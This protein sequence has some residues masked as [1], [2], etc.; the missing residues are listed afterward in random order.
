MSDQHEHNTLA[1]SAMLEGGYEI[2]DASD[3]ATELRAVTS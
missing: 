1:L 3:R 2:A